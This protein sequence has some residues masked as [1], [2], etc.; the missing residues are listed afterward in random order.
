MA[1]CW[2]E[3]ENNQHSSSLQ[4][5]QKYVSMSGTISQTTEAI[6]LTED[7]IKEMNNAFIGILSLGF[8]DFFPLRNYPFKH[9]VICQTMH[10]A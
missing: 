9:L 4:R 8:R 3:T 1:M 10:L 7:F 5:L 6:S 2:E